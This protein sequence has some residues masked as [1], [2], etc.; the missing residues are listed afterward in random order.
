MPHGL[1]RYHH[2]G[3]LHFLTFST[4]HR[5][6]TLPPH[7]LLFERLLEDTRRTHRFEVHGYVLMP[8]HVHLLVSEPEEIPLSGALHALKL[9]T[10]KHIHAG[11]FWQSRYYDFNVFTAKKRLEKLHY[12]HHNPVKRG[13]VARAEDWPHSSARHWLHAEPHPP[14]PSPSSP[15]YPDPH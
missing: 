9:S 8:E 3:H 10:S 11:P 15:P 13:L 5:K 7:Y 2:T 14:S 1:I 6:P 4:H 12:M